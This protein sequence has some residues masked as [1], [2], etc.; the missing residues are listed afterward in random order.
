MK[1]NAYQ[2]LVQWKNSARRKPLILRGARQVG[3]TW[4]MNEFA[5]NEYKNSIYIS[6]Y[7][8]DPAKK[9]FEDTIDAKVLLERLSLFAN[10]E[11]A[12]GKT[13]LIFDEIQDCPNAVASLKSFNE[14][15]N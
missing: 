13:L 4:L 1:R 7:K 10:K 12:A 8:N 11:I 6:F 3:K 15:A 5:K 14:D 2:K 9:L